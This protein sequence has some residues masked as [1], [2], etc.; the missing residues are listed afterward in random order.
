MKKHLLGENSGHSSPEHKTPKNFAQNAKNE[1]L[2]ELS[3]ES[4]VVSFW[5]LLLFVA[6]FFGIAAEEANRSSFT[7]P[8]S[9]ISA[10]TNF[11]SAPQTLSNLRDATAQQF[12][13]TSR[14][15]AEKL[16][17]PATGK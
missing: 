1:M 3:N 2:N 17:V 4:D 14:N 12:D 13:L 7:S 9:A 15:R 10:S 6:V 5:L 16:E 8:S 11:S